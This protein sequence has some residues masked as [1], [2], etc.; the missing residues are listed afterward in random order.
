MDGRL[1]RLRRPSA[2]GALGALGAHWVRWVRWVLWYCLPR[3][4]AHRSR[5]LVLDS[6]PTVIYVDGPM[7]AL[8]YEEEV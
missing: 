5:R 8:N 1:R 2:L 4:L 6:C 3:G 7:E